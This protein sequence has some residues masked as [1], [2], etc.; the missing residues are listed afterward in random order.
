V[1][2]SHEIRASAGLVCSRGLSRRAELGDLWRARAGWHR[3]PDTCLAWQTLAD[4]AV[5]DP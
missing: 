2:S 3:N 1:A 4:D 5:A